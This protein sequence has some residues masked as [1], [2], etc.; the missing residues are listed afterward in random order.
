[1]P[2]SGM[3]LYLSLSTC[4]YLLHIFNVHSQRISI[5]RVC[6]V[7]TYMYMYMPAKDSNLDMEPKFRYGKFESKKIF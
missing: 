7:S 5:Y 6:T 3:L 2:C 4:I 1:M